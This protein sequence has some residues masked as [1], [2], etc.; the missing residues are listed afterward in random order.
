[1]TPKEKTKF[2][3]CEKNV[4][5]DQTKTSLIRPILLFNQDDSIFRTN[6]ESRFKDRW[7]NLMQDQS[8]ATNFTRE[9]EVNKDDSK[10]LNLT[11][12]LKDYKVGKVWIKYNL[13]KKF[14]SKLCNLIMTC[15]TFN[16][17]YISYLT[18][19]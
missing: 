4:Q 8:H 14:S 17:F 19:R 6:L 7:N 18:A 11:L 9:I 2:H 3:D 12:D 15:L 16:I 10:E 5:C 1:M 13:L